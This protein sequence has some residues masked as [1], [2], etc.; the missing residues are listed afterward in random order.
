MQVGFRGFLR[1][2]IPVGQR[3]MQRLFPRI[4]EKRQRQRRQS[5]IFSLSSD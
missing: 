2:F 1:E 3:A 4:A 5:R